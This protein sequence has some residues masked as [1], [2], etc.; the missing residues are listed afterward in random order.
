[1]PA[2][3]QNTK[4]VKLGVCRVIYDGYDLGYT[5][6]GVE[7]E[8]ATETYKVEVDQFGKSPINEYIMGR[9]V[10]VKCP[11]AETT[12]ENLALTMPG[13]VLTATGGVKASGTLIVASIPANNATVTVNG[14]VLTYKTVA[15][16]AHDVLIGA[17]TAATAANLQAVLQTSNAPELLAAQYT[18]TAST[19][20]VTYDTAGIDGNAFTL[21][22]GSAATTVSGATLTGGVNASKKKVMV[23]TSISTDL[24]SIAKRL[25]L[26]PKSLADTDKSEDFIVPLA[27]T[28]GALSFAYKLDQERIYN[29]TFNGYPDCAT[30]NLFIVGDETA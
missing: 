29:V 3:C 7:V 1:M 26:H 19:V 14:I 11:L 10:S 28:S 13:A 21:V 17:T 20:T 12:L 22:A 27:A 6:G 5:K 18:V 16:A 30:N 24:L 8:V 9:T 15:S 4:N 2:I 23:G 25:V